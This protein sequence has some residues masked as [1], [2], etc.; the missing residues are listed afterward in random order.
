MELDQNKEFYELVE[1]FLNNYEET[2]FQNYYLIG[3]FPFVMQT[4]HFNFIFFH[5]NSMIEIF[6][7][8]V[9]LNHENIERVLI[10]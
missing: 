1:L 6:C 9:E 10:N 3:L 4:R 7:K 8:Y 2:D 5:L